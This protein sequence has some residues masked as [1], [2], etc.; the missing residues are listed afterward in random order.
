MHWAYSNLNKGNRSAFFIYRDLKN[1]R[2]ARIFCY[3]KAFDTSPLR[4]EFHPITFE[5]YKPMIQDI[6][7]MIYYFLLLHGDSKNPQI[8]PIAIAEKYARETIHLFDL[9]E[10]VRSSGLTP[11]VNQERFGWS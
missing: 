7:D 9:E 1:P 4:V 11:T 3:L 8:R 6:L 2:N 10:I 5:K